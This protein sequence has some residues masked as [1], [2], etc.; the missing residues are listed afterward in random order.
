MRTGQCQ[1]HCLPRI[2]EGRATI[3]RPSLGMLINLAITRPMHPRTKQKIKKRLNGL[4]LLLSGQARRRTAQPEAPTKVVPLQAGDRV[5]VRSRPQIEATLDYWGELK[6]CGILDG[7]WQYCDTSQQVLKPLKRFLDE[8]EFKMKR[9]RG[10]VLLD[11]VTCEGI[12]AFGRCDRSCYFFWRQEW[13][14]KIET[15]EALRVD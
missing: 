6:G 3:P 8:R 15:L 9:C 10:I 4:M 13:L 5:R 7:M 12:D 2:S 11:G 14:E 1:I